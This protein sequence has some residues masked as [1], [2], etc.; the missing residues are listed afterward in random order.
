M[1]KA[2]A[3]RHEVPSLAQPGW[4]FGDSALA[5][6]RPEAAPQSPWGQQ[7]VEGA[8]GVRVQRVLLTGAGGCVGRAVLA[9]AARMPVPPEIV[10][11]RHSGTRPPTPGVRTLVAGLEELPALLDQAGPIDACIHAAAAVHGAEADPARV[12]ATN[13]DA[14]L[15]LARALCGRPGFARFVFVST[16]AVLDESA[17]ATPYAASKREAEDGLAQLAA[18]A[19]FELSVLRFATVYGPSDRGNIGSLYRAIA[20]RRYVR[21]APPDTVKTL[22]SSRRAAA[23]ALAAAAG[24]AAG[25]WIVADPEPY[26]LEVVEDALADAADVP[27]PL[28]LPRAVGWTL[29]ACGSAARALGMPA[30]FTLA[31]LR[32]LARPA[33]FRPAPPSV[34]ADAMRDADR[35]PLDQAFRDA[36]VHGLD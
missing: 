35:R 33:A 9:S 10:A 23:A 15:A 27:R 26:P 32:T 8:I 11:V 24:G 20:R 30:P 28:R 4:T 21:V 19:G 25:K 18:E 12:F 29:A 7:S 6:A 22:L 31:R 34:L 17:R 5:A 13:R 36:Y 16:V 2:D 1:D 14:T 3:G